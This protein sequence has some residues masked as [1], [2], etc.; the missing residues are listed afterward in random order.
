MLNYDHLSFAEAKI[1]QEEFRKQLKFEIPNDL[2]IKTIAGAD[3]SYD[4]NSTLMFAAIIILSYPDL[5]LKA[6]SLTTSET[7]FPYKAGYLGFREV[8]TL[9]KAWEQ[10]A[11]KPDVVVLD[12]QGILHPRRMGIAAHFGVLTHT[13]TIGCAKSSLYG[14]Y[15]KP[16]I[17]KYSLNQ[18]YEKGSNEH[19]GYAIRSKTNNKLIYISPGYGLTLPKSLAIIKNC[20]GKYRIPEP[21]RIAHDIVNEFR[22]GKLQ[23]GFK[24]VISPLELF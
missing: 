5:K 19:I 2:E 12:G 11:I 6:Y 4:Q 8:P 1:I 16:A 7:K 3:I 23:S 24:E 21:T 15:E 9:L 10:I 18:V 13:P 22:I 20:I 14:H 17:S